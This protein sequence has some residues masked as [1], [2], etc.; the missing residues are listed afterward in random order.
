MKKRIDKIRKKKWKALLAAGIVVLFSVV[1]VAAFQEASVIYRAISGKVA[2]HLEEYTVR[3]GEET[4]WTDGQVVMPGGSISKI[5]RIYNDGEPCY[6][7][8][9][10]EFDC[11]GETRVPLSVDNLEGISSQWIHCGDYFYYTQV[12]Q[13]EDSVDFFKGI[14]MPE[15]WE[16]GIDDGKNW[17]ARVKVDAVQADFFQPDFTSDDPWKMGSRGYQIQKAIDEEPESQEKNSEPVSLEV[18]AKMQGFQTDTREFFRELET[19]VPGKSQMGTVTITNQTGK[20]REVFIRSE[21][22]EENEFLEELELT[23]R[24]RN[25]DRVQV[26]YQ[27]VF[28]AKELNEYRSIGKISEE[29]TENIEFLIHMPEEA[30]N[31]YS[32]KQGKVKFTFTTE[33]P[34]QPAALSAVKTGDETAVWI[35][36]GLIFLMPCMAGIILYGRKG[37]AERKRKNGG[38]VS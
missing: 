13:K 20:E 26:I 6:V 10:V 15:Q 4:E 32:A 34:D 25:K 30:D 37:K 24:V 23:V 5:P 8:A 18:D 38:K 36:L 33:I 27:G 31:R 16:S 3:D 2:V 29:S 9:Q 35:Y 11:D 12:L 1:G 17:Q 28:N 19:F 22:L 21:I 14:K 7:R